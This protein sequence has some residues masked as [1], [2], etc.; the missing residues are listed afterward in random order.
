MLYRILIWAAALLSRLFFSLRVLGRERVP[1]T[2]PFLLVAN[3]AS[4][5]DPVVA[6]VACPRPLAFMAKAE[7]FR[8]P[9]L[10]WLI[11]RVHAFPVRRDGADP[12][13]FRRALG[14]LEGGRPLLVFPEGTRGSEGILRPAKA[15]AGMLAVR[16]GVPVVPAYIQGTGTALG[17]GQK[18]PRLV[19]LTVAFGP[20]I[21]FDRGA[22]GKRAYEAAASRM[23]AA[24]ARLQEEVTGRPARW[25]GEADRHRR[26]RLSS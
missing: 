5:F 12:S 14:V 10:G 17:R 18:W 3:H 21:E 16:S 20:P 23:M 24:I 1:L 7:L 26:V 22:R 11:R 25:E 15:G 19:P 6:G 8:V 13:A 4:F 9:F 2:G